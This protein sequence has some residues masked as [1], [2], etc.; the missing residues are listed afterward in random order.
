MKQRS[1]IPRSVDGWA[2]IEREGYVPGEKT[3]VVRHT[4][5]G[6]RKERGDDP[7]PGL[8]V[9][10]F[11][12]PPGAVTRL[13][14]HEHEHYVI[15]GEGVGVAIV[16][17][18]ACEVRR[19]DVVYVAPLQA[20]QFVNRGNETFGFFCV[21]TAT[22]DFSQS[23]APDELARMLASPAGAYLDPD[24][25]PPPRARPAQAS[26]GILPAEREASKCFTT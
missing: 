24:G 9:R 19:N 14:K 25:A 11:S 22:R 3:N 10:Y 6:G 8:E 23:L 12:V 7:G 16:G 5:V 15:V 18:R 17:E 4:L 1:F 26:G 21:V 2:E 13:E 20:H